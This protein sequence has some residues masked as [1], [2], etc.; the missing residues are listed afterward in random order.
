MGNTIVNC[1]SLDRKTKRMT[2]IICESKIDKKGIINY[3]KQC[4]IFDADD[5]SYEY[6]NIYN[7][8]MEI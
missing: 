3:C 4:K 1:C 6:P 5:S 2:C 7:V 8:E